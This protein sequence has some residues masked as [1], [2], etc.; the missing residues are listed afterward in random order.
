M[1]DGVFKKEFTHRELY[2]YITEYWHI[3]AGTEVD[4]EAKVTATVESP[5]FIKPEVSVIRIRVKTYRPAPKLL[6]LIGDATPAGWDM[7]QAIPMNEDILGKSYRWRG[8]LN[9]GSFKFIT[10]LGNN[11]PSL[12]KGDEDNTLV[13]RTSESQADN[14]FTVTESGLYTII[15]KRD[16]MKIAILSFE[17]VWMVGDAVPTGWD[18][19]NPTPMTWNFD[20]PDE[21]VYEG[22]L[23]GWKELKMPLGRGSW[24]VD[25]LMPVVHGSTPLGDGTWEQGDN[26][27]QFVPGGSPDNKWWTPRPDGESADWK[28]ILNVKTMTIDF[29]KK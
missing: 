13:E 20:R 11:L 4:L 1:A 14:L 2:E 3:E 19:D 10:R 9:P 23:I 12:N 21:F 15:I 22:I 29:Q 8:Y 17:N 24:D 25:F 27:V 6:Y 5:T 26:R 28:V 18:I 16:E 7:D